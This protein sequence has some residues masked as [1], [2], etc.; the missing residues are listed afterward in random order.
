M[1][2]SARC[3]KVVF[4]SF[5]S[6]RKF[7]VEMEVNAKLSQN[8][9]ADVIYR[10]GMNCNVVG[11]GYTIGNTQWEVKPDSTCG[12]TG[13]KVNGVGGYEAISP[14]ARGSDHLLNIEKVA[15]G[16]A[17]AGAVVNKYCG[18]HCH[19]EITDFD[20]YKAAVTAANWLRLERLI[21]HMVPPHRVSQ[22]GGKY[23]RLLS[24]KHTINAHDLYDA[25]SF[26]RLVK[27]RTLNPEGK[28]TA[29]SFINYCRS[30][31]PD[32]SSFRNRVT[33]ELRLPEG[34]LNPAD[35]KNWAR[36]FVHFV[37]T[38]ASRQFP[39]N[40]SFVGIEDGLQIM[41]LADKEKPTILSAGLY[42]TRMWVLNRILRFSRSESLKKE[43]RSLLARLCMDESLATE[44][45]YT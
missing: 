24:S 15:A 37:D 5:V 35:A 8:A 9:L 26:W 6:E 7:G 11:W 29:I 42:E 20:D 1:R 40:L 32:W 44:G 10:C 25:T 39:T 43:A 12:D 27:P 4:L 14:A 3:P 22:T 30:K 45:V 36:F 31:H 16:L 34:S 28:R 18:F 21:A 38:C 23:C 19:V 17:K 13:K 41:G 33:V 2:E